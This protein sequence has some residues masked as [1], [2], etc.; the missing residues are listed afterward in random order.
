MK[1]ILVAIAAML[2]TFG[3][4]AQNYKTEISVSYGALSNSQILSAVIFAAEAE[5]AG[6]E[7]EKAKFIGPISADLYFRTS[8]YFSFGLSGVYQHTTA[9]YSVP[10]GDN[11][12]CRYFSLMPGMKLHWLR[13]NGFNMYSKLAVG[14]TFASNI[15][16]ERA[17]LLNFQVSPVGLE[18]GRRF[19]VFAEAGFGEQGIV[20]GGIRLKL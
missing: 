19:C 18:F 9:K 2:I 14:P 12:E 13:T 3:A 16:G 15:D 11:F 4:S 1:K 10:N 17:W 20:L 7:L 5:N 8:K 6:M